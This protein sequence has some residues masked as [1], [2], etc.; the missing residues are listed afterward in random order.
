MMIIPTL[1]MKTWN[2]TC[3]RS[4]WWEGFTLCA[5]SFLHVGLPFL[6]VHSPR[7][8]TPRSLS[9]GRI[10]IVTDTNNTITVAYTLLTTYR[11]HINFCIHYLKLHNFMRFTGQVIITILYMMKIRLRNIKRIDQVNMLIVEDTGLKLIFY[12]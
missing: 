3:T 10:F 9:P 11:F 6:D 2:E 1:Q 5:F 7:D 12:L 8:W 4:W